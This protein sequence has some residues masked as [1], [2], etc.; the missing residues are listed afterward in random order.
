MMID[1]HCHLNFKAFNKDRHQ[2]IERAIKTG[3]EKIIIP[4]AKIDSS[5]KGVEI[6]QQYESC[7][8][9]VGIHPHHSNQIDE[10]QEELNSLVK[11]AKVVAVGEIGLDYHR[12]HNYPPIS[13]SVKKAQ[14]ELFL[15]QLELAKKMHLPVIIHC[16]E[17]YEDLLTILE[18]SAAKG[19]FRG[20]FHCFEGTE[21]QLTEVLDLGFYAG[22]DGNI[23][24]EENSLLRKLV[25]LTPL[26]RL[27]LE[28]DAP[29]LTPL[30]FRGQRNEPAFITYLTKCV[31]EIQ[32]KSFE[33]IA[34]IIS[35]NAQ[36]L[37]NI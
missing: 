22:F 27:L 20:V 28:T 5:K 32:Q 25:K 30:P 4:G 21:K 2:V 18:M 11:Q 9:A 34:G 14:R 37:F 16:R 8:A 1:T 35:F 26:D 29:F 6:A 7:Y 24:Y 23:T 33:D 36:K 15:L 17:A 10:S 31:A 3:V 12:Y 13:S 19:Q